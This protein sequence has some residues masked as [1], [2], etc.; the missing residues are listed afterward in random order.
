MSDDARDAVLADCDAD[1][2]ERDLTERRSLA[3]NIGNMLQYDFFHLRIIHPFG[4]LRA[5]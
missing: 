2:V 5:L 4:V 3:V 1:I